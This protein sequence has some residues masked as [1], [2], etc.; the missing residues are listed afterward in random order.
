MEKLKIGTH[1]KTTE[2]IEKYGFNFK[3]NFG[4]NFLIDSHVLNKIVDSSEITDEDLVIE[5]G[6]GIGSLTEYLAERAKKVVCIEIDKKLIPIL[7]E[8][9]SEH[10]NVEIINDDILKVDLKKIMEEQGFKKAKMVANLPYYITTPIIMN[11]LENDINIETITVMIQKEVAKRMSAKEGT[12][13]YGSLTIAVQYYSEPYLVA[14][15]PQNCFKPRPNV[16]SA[17]IRLKKKS[18]KEVVV[19]DEKLMFEII[20]IAFSQRRKT[21]LNCIFNSTQFNFNKQEIEQIL[22][23]A[24]LDIKIRGEKLTIKQFA[25]LT[26]IIYN[27]TITV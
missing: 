1:K 20:K 4:Q 6:P 11:V 16:D 12:K 7:N 17:V 23:E 3:K 21:L 10:D 18:K 2:I 8:T 15:V 9:L 25:N 5:V 14:N 19:S 26:D 24:D 13:D 27:K 22:I